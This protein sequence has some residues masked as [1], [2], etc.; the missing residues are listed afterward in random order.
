MHI[1]IA[2]AQIRKEKKIPV[3]RK[4]DQSTAEPFYFETRKM[5]GT[6]SPKNSRIKETKRN[7]HFH[8][9]FLLVGACKAKKK[10]GR[11]GGGEG[12]APNALPLLE[13]A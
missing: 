5:W 13:A 3:V 4:Y 11:G 2:R 7:F 8:F 12:F 9:Q 6:T 1:I 10:R